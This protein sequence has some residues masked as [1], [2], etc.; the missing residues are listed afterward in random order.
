MWGTVEAAADGSISWH[1]DAGVAL[2]PILFEVD[3]VQLIVDAAAPENIVALAAVD[4]DKLRS[5]A[6][7]FTDPAVIAT[8]A[9]AD[10]GTE[11]EGPVA[12]DAVRRVA[13]VEAVDSL[14][15]SDL[16]EGVLLL[17]HAFAATTAGNLGRGAEHFMLASV[18]ADR[19]VTEIADHDYL[20]PLN[21]R[22][23][24]A[25]LAAPEGTFPDGDR[26][27]YISILR[28]RLDRTDGPWRT[29]VEASASGE[30]A[31]TLGEAQSVSAQIADL[32]LVPR[33]L[34]TFG[35]PDVPEV[36]ITN[37]DD[38]VTLSAQLRP[39]VDVD[40]AEANEVFA[41]V[42]DEE[43][44]ELLS[45]A[46]ARVVGDRVEA[47]V[48]LHGIDP[49]TVRCA[50]VG[51]EVNIDSVRLDE[52]GTRIAG[53]DRQCRFAWSEH[54]RAGALL[55]SVS[56]SSTEAEVE[57]VARAASRAR[58]SAEREVKSA[59][60]RASRLSG[61]AGLNQYAAA[62]TWLSDRLAE[63]PATDGPTGPTIA[64]LY[65]VAY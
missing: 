29:F 60:K 30:L 47:T 57:K 53:I 46:P 12:G 13:T 2:G 11:T 22:L 52:I 34:L 18:V 25:V 32:R 59:A 44:G 9:A 23:L 40:G 63:A 61:T 45:H 1:A 58:K 17:D 20:G 36:T 50:L 26:T 24:E 43:T 37:G 48:A 49:D 16:D 27:E 65:A 15:L 51:S 56:A 7:W 31:L 10:D 39:S 54:R 38:E 8:I 62:V 4:A 55:A 19:M 5:V 3:G 41:V 35:G 21:S 33:R 14:V 64:E 6:H 42:A 28:G